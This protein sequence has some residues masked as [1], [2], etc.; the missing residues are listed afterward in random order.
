MSKGAVFITGASTGIGKCTALHLDKA[1]YRV[2]AGVRKE[3]DAD[4]LRAEASDRLQPILIDVTKEEQI[5]EA[6]REVEE[7]LGDDT[8]VGLVNNAGVA[9]LG[10]LEFL[11]P[12]DMRWQME[13]NIVG[14]L[15]VTQAFTKLLRASKGRI[16]NVGSIAGRVTT[17]YSAAYSASKF[18]L[19]AITIGMR[20]EMSPWDVWACVVDPGQIKTPIWGKARESY[21]RCKE[22]LGKEGWALYGDKLEKATGTFEQGENGADPL[23]VAQAIEHGLCAGRPKTRYLVGKDARL[24]A[25]LQW[26][27]P[28][29]AFE[30]VLLSQR[31]G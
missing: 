27:L 28:D 31:G 9:V 15:M 12:D 25:A 22:W 20:M 23:L 29:K 3:K 2:F 4:A 30:K 5:K 19:E 8:L 11:P 24:G 6:A 10:P 17:P 13:V 7:A 26:L 21:E 18:A 14:V 16:I 1:G